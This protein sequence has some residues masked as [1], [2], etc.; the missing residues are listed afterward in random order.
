MKA[1]VIR[2][3]GGRCHRCSLAMLRAHAWSAETQ[4]SPPWL[5]VR[6]PT[7][8]CRMIRGFGDRCWRAEE[9]HRCLPTRPPKGFRLD[10]QG[11][12][13]LMGIEPTTARTTTECSTPELQ[14]PPGSAVWD[15]GAQAVKG[16]TAQPARVR[17]VI[18]GG[19]TAPNPL[20]PAAAL[21]P[22]P[23]TLSP[24]RPVAPCGRTGHASAWWRDAGW[25][26]THSAEAPTRPLPRSRTVGHASSRRRHGSP[27]HRNRV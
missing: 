11:M 24:H 18:S 10:R 9:R 8:L 13:R 17:L 15:T 26:P 3:T 2:S 20:T 5:P 19:S 14:P 23:R 4:S 7:A 22:I 27:W 1:H 21:A 12:G 16:E 25:R 6:R